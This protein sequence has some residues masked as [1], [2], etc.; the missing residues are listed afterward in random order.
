MFIN[1]CGRFASRCIKV[2]K[3][4]PARA[5]QPISLPQQEP[6][7]AYDNRELCKRPPSPRYITSQLRQ[8]AFDGGWGNSRGQ[9]FGEPAGSGHF[10]EIEIRQ[11]PHFMGRF[12]QAPAVPSPDDRYRYRYQKAWSSGIRNTG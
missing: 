6:T 5:N 8:L 3:Q 7:A 2:E 9:Q 10:L 4:L 11:T 1:R 12:D